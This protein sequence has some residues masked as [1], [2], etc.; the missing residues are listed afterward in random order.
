MEN[1]K[2]TLAFILFL[3]FSANSISQIKVN[4]TGEIK[5]GNEWPNND[6]NN[7]MSIEAFGLNTIAYRPGAKLSFGDYGAAVNWG[8][9]VFVGEFGTTDTD[10]LQLNGKYGIHF[11]TGGQ[12]TYE[13]ARFTSGGT[14]EVRGA[15]NANS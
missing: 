1:F 5:I 14:L 4:L 3:L 8:A 6:Y 13:V 9:N 12:G 11:T 2:I 7:E 10:A 15:V